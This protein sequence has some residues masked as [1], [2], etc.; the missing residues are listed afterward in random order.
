MKRLAAWVGSGIMRVLIAYARAI[1]L[2]VRLPVAR[3]V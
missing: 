1:N 2:S 3:G